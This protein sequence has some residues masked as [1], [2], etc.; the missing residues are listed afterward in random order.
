MVRCRCFAIALA[1]LAFALQ[2][3]SQE[4]VTAGKQTKDFDFSGSQ[5]WLD[6]GL[7]VKAGD[8]LAI[9]AT[10]TLQYPSYKQS[11]PEGLSRGWRDLMRIFPLSNS[12]HGALIG[13][14]GAEPAQPFLIGPKHE[15]RAF[16]SGRLFLGLNQTDSEHPDGTLHVHVEI[17]PGAS[18]PAVI[19]ESKLP[20]LTQAILD[21]IPTRVSDAA[22]NLGD[23]VNFLIV[24]SETQLT[25]ALQ[26]AG[27][28]Q[29]N[30]TVADAFIEGALATFSKQAYTQLPMSELQLYGR[31]QDFGYAQADPLV[32]VAAR[33]HFR[34][35]K[36]PIEVDGQTLWVG[37][38][39][40]DIGIEKDKRNGKLTHKIDPETDLEREHIAQTLQGTGE[41]AKLY[42]MTASK[43]VTNA[44]TATGGSF[45]SDG[46]TL[47]IILNPTDN[48]AADTAAAKQ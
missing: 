32:V 15:S 40:H 37:A 29:V 24:G 16:T 30:R 5:K 18:A 43:P 31:P 28:V 13:R 19:D 33:H 7:D 35:W 23:R 46:R 9:T 6:T 42:Y 12:N 41:V 38:G 21:Q 10:G 25:Q 45:K 14:I 20:K 4:A 36:A 3:Y 11:G 1:C 44:M 22:G 27:W 48:N 2:F 34:I 17:T 39:T 47:T 26:S 8:S